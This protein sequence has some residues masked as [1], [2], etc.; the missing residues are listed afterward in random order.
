M[1]SPGGFSP[2]SDETL[3]TFV[4]PQFQGNPL[5][6]LEAL[7][8]QRGSDIPVIP[9]EEAGSTTVPIAN[10]H[11]DTPRGHR[12][13]RAAGALLNVASGGAISRR[14]HGLHLAIEGIDGTGKSTALTNV[15]ELLKDSGLSVSKV[16]Y[17]SKSG[18]MGQII[19]AVYQQENSNRVLGKIAGFRPLQA[20]MYAINGRINLLRRQRGA[21]VLLVD[22][23]VLSGYASHVGRV[24]GWLISATESLHAPDVIAYL[25]LPLDEA[26]R[27]IGVREDGSVGYE[28]DAESLQKFSDDY[29]TVIAKPPR[30]LRRTTI[31]RIDANRSEAEVARS[32]AEVALRSLSAPRHKG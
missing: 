4:P 18:V 30:R 20:A 13:L 11:S 22:R 27:R 21:D 29:E 3:G 5:Q 8:Q 14:G 6:E 9:H 25:Q 28:E 31:E 26:S 23:S 32:I 17:T 15:E 19:G 16:R 1:S 10:A 24:P 2:K 7:D 12:F